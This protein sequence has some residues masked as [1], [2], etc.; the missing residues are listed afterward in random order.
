MRKCRRGLGSERRWGL[1][2]VDHGDFD[3]S[4]TISVLDMERGVLD[5]YRHS[6]S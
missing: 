3:S 5:A 4:T 2:S 1:G 6:P